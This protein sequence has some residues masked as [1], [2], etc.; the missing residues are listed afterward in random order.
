MSSGNI[1]TKV[2]DLRP[3]Q[4]LFSGGV[5]AAIDLPNLS[6]IVMG[7]DDWDTAYANELGEERLLAAVKRGL[8]RSVKKLLSPPILPETKAMPTPADEAAR[9]GLPVAPFPTLTGRQ[10]A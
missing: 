10:V 6:A 3:S 2:G 5:G 7:L 4:I 1:K 8:N 9:I